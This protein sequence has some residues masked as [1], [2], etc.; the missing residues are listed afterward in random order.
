MGPGAWASARP[1]VPMALRLD[2]ESHKAKLA[3]LVRDDKKTTSP[4]KAQPKVEAAPSPSPSAVDARAPPP[5]SDHTG[6]G[7]DGKTSKGKGKGGNKGKDKGKSVNPGKGPASWP[8]WR[9]TGF[10][11]FYKGN[12]SPPWSMAPWMKGAGMGK[13]G[14]AKGKKN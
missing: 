1:L 10:N 2:A 12:G 11:P 13:G 8:A 7:K 6:K 9:G 14:P 5:P 3:K 4:V